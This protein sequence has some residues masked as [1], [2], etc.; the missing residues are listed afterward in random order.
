[1][2]KKAQLWDAGCD[3]ALLLWNTGSVIRT[4]CQRN[5]ISA[6]SFFLTRADGTVFPVN[7]QLGY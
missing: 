3:N 4:D 7:F 2:R 6:L 5:I 1:M